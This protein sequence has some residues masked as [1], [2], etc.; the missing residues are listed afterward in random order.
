ML[1]KSVSRNLVDLPLN[2][3]SIFQ[4]RVSLFDSGC[5]SCMRRKVLGG[6]VAKTDL[7]KSFFVCLAKEVHDRTRSRFVL[8]LEL[9]HGD[10]TQGFSQRKL[11]SGK[12]T[13]TM[14]PIAS[15]PT[16]EGPDPQ[17]ASF[18]KCL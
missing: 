11:R 4:P 6:F 13:S 17:R 3:K 18:V 1:V 8:D 14:V 7:S 2:K 9:V 10:G 16:T 15:A 5:T 12:K